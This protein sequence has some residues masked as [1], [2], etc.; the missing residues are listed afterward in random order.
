[1]EGTTIPRGVERMVA[2]PS[3]RWIALATTAGLELRTSANLALLRMWRDVSATALA[4][5][6]AEEALIVGSKDGL[7]QVFDTR[8]GNPW[9]NQLRFT[10]QVTSVAYRAIDGAIL[11]TDGHHVRT[12]LRKEEGDG[13]V[14][15]DAAKA[16]GYGPMIACPTTNQI[17]VPFNPEGFRAWNP[18]NGSL[19]RTYQLGPKKTVIVDVAGSA[20]GNWLAVGSQQQS[21]YLWNTRTEK[22]IGPLDFQGFSK[23]K[24]QSSHRIAIS[25]NGRYAAFSGMDEVVIYSLVDN[26]PHRV[27]SHPTK[28][29]GSSW[30]SALGISP[31]SS[32]LVVGWRR[33]AGDTGSPVA[34]YDLATG[35]QTALFYPHKTGNIHAVIAFEDGRIFTSSASGEA[36]L[37][38]H[39]QKELKNYVGHIGAV[40]GAAV[41]PDERR[42]ATAGNDGTVRLWD[43]ETGLELF[44]LGKH[45]GPGMGV[46]F[47]PD[48]KR[49]ASTG[50]D[51]T[52]RIWS[53]VG[54][55]PVPKSPSH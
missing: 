49:V 23:G 21:A 37:W 3:G 42:L 11:A 5:V 13:R 53:A 34:C 16:S 41:S 45:A 9:T 38:D 30:A 7:V 44:T 46:A 22:K 17:L 40:N 14:I 24:V 25:P 2:D 20:D 10:R 19:L 48:G 28:S 29:G 43:I 1:M 52:L 35:E 55:P 4:I 39:R 6:P 33:M 31:D 36:K 15:P 12:M 26:Q 27:L 18:A 8:D 50:R 51:G 47:S 32:T 54:T